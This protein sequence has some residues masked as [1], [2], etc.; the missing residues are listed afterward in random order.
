[1]N[2]GNALNTALS[3][4]NAAQS[5]IDLV[6]R[7]IANASVPGY[8]EKTRAQTTGA[9][10]GVV[11]G[12]V[13]RA[14]EAGMQK[15]SWDSAADVGMLDAQ[16]RYASRITTSFGSPADATSLANL[17]AAL[18]DAFQALSVSPETASAYTAVVNAA[19]RLASG[20]LSLYGQA[21]QSADDAQGELSDAVAAAN[22]DL[23]SIDALNKQ[24]MAGAGSDTTD[25]QDERDR[26]IANIAQKL[27][28]TTFTRTDG[29]IAV[30]TKRGTALVDATANTLSVTLSADGLAHQLVAGT[31]A[32][33][34][35]VFPRS[36][37]IKGLLDVI[38][39]QVPDLQAQ[40]DNF[41]G[42][43]AGAT[44][45]A[46][47]DAGKSL[48]NDAGE[49]PFDPTDAAQVRGFGARIA[50]NQAIVQNP[51][52]IRE[53]GSATALAPGDTTYIDAVRDVLKSSDFAG[54][55]SDIIT[56][57]S[58][59]ASALAGSLQAEKATQTA[60]DTRIS[61]A[62]GV[63]LDAEFSH[64]LQLQQAYAANAR[65]ITATQSMFDTL[66]AAVGGT[67]AG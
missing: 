10:G 26:A 65:I 58:D 40:L 29:G 51:A 53:G 57:Q 34:S 20:I 37:A 39:T 31:A 32:S 7:N 48:F 6:S 3:G 62:T 22:R 18:G 55:A 54:A 15:A 60:I 27:D 16:Q 46:I 63:N 11:A 2:V 30:Y 5:G 1:M 25:L 42:N 64:L 52:S 24:I 38:D 41:A 56:G 35:Q 9:D 17:T 8:T 47:G 44:A 28:I 49:T 50:V 23:A 14:V 33:Q 21:Q 19:D 12:D 59:K 67:A 43:L 66:F 45:Q 61:S 13:R 4:L 36:G